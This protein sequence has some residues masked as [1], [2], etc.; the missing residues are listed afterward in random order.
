[1]NIQKTVEKVLFKIMLVAIPLTLTVWLYGISVNAL[2]DYIYKN[3]TNIV[4]TL[5]Q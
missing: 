1:M 4:F 2:A 3:T 5:G